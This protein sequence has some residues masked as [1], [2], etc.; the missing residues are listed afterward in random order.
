MIVDVSDLISAISFCFFYFWRFFM[1][2]YIFLSESFISE[3][4][5]ICLPTCMIITRILRILGSKLLFLVFSIGTLSESG[6]PQ[7]N[8]QHRTLQLHPYVFF[9]RPPHIST[10][11]RIS[12]LHSKLDLITK[13]N[14]IC[15]FL[16]YI[17]E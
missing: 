7:F 12:H 13:P 5:F 4:I 10:M 16:L 15:G 2:S 9:A 11:L 14:P 17:I 6:E 1:A 3:N 8:F